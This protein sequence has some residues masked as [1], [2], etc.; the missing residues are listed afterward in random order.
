MQL[1]DFGVNILSTAQDQ[2]LQSPAPTQ[3]LTCTQNTY[4][5]NNFLTQWNKHHSAKGCAS[6]QLAIH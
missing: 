6:M 2:S 4:E 3:S 1:G 5:C